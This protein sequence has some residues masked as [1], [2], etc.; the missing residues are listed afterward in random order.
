[1]S[2]TE[3]RLKDLDMKMY[4]AA[5]VKVI[6]IKVTIF[7]AMAVSSLKVVDIGS[8]MVTKTD[9]VDMNRVSL[10]VDADESVTKDKLLTKVA[11]RL[12]DILQN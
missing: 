7:V 6:M 11:N 3:T 12:A 8:T 2:G 5:R 10:L 4:T 9:K 1:M